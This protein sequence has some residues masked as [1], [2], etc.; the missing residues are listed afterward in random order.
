MATDS[1]QITGTNIR[2]DALR[3][4]SIAARLAGESLV[5][6]ISNAADTRAKPIIKR[7]NVRLPSDAEPIKS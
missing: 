7:F 4:A 1:K 5:D 3:R 2:P 6:F